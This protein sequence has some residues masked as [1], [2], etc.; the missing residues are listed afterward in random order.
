M[1]EQEQ[2]VTFKYRKEDWLWLERSNGPLGPYV[3]RRL[4]EKADGQKA[5]VTSLDA[6]SS[7]YFSQ[8]QW[9]QLRF[10][11][12]LGSSSQPE[13]DEG[14]LKSEGWLKDEWPCDIAAPVAALEVCAKRP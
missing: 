2:I 5:I 9:V 3:S 1:I 7:S 8:Q 4:L 10:L 12:P 14:Q 6:G 11:E 13:Y